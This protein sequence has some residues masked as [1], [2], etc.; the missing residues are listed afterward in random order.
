[1][2]RVTIEAPNPR[3]PRQIRAKSA[4]LRELYAKRVNLQ[5]TTFDS[6]QVRTGNERDLAS[7]VFSIATRHSR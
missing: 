1:M 3:E 6:H 5:T 4:T 2:T 7:S